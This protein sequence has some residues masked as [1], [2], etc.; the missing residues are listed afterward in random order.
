MGGGGCMT[1]FTN[2][3]LVLLMVEHQQLLVQLH[4]L[5]FCFIICKVFLFFN[6]FQKT[7]HR[8]ILKKIWTGALHNLP[9]II[10]FLLQHYRKNSQGILP[11]ITLVGCELW[12]LT[13]FG[14]KKLH[15]KN[16]QYS[17]RFLIIP[18]IHS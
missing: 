15:M 4:L 8:C 10:I 18:H 1:P 11:N 2:Y 6:T 14:P 12:V 9:F 3:E 17:Q 16:Q 5:Q 7:L 13:H